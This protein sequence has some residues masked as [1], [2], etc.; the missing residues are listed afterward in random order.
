MMHVMVRLQISVAK[1]CGI[2]S[3]DLLGLSEGCTVAGGYIFCRCFTDYCNT[4]DLVDKSQLLIGT[5]STF[6]EVT[7]SPNPAT[8]SSPRFP[9]TVTTSSSIVPSTSWHCYECVNCGSSIGTLHNCTTFPSSRA[10]YLGRTSN[11]E[12]MYNSKLFIF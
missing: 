12:G 10:C 11:G 7:R 9:N 3:F 5:N 4:L 1:S 8:R 6:S 2:Q